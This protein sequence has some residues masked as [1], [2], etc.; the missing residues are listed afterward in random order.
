MIFM[1]KTL[2]ILT[3]GFPADESDSNCLPAQ[4]QFVVMLQENFPGLQIIIVTVQYPAFGKDYLWNHIRVI[5][6][7]IQKGFYTR[8]AWI[9]IWNALKKLKDE[10]SISG[11][12]IF[13]CSVYALPAFWLART[14]HIPHYCWILGQDA[15]KNN[16]VVKLIRPKPQELIAI[17]DA[18]QNEFYENHGVKAAHVIPVGV[19]KNSFGEYAG[20]RFIDILGAGSLIPL[21]QYH[22]FVEIVKSHLSSFPDLKALLFGR[23]TEKEMLQKKIRQLH[24]SHNLKLM[25][26]ISHDELVAVMHH[27]KIFLHPSA[28]EG[29]SSAC[30][31]AL[32]AGAHVISFQRPMER[33][34]PHWHTVNSTYE[35]YLMTLRLL[36]S[37]LLD[38]EEIV[39]Y[40][41]NSAT[42]QIMA[43]F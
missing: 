32:S 1:Q 10:N 41:M 4:Q 39:P 7:N 2:I 3:P 37:D 30:L 23:G 21:K 36:Q 22:L 43:L 26:E 34:L 42:K 15:R 31:E 19:N 6:L 8:F 28:Y 18:L 12:V 25:D 29:F 13:W 20:G 40:S 11:L 14:Y 33:D 35:M 24:I 5:S 16:H 38:H 27:G 17:S 9:K